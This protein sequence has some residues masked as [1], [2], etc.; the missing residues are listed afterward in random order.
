MIT[1][2]LYMN[3]YIY[4]WYLVYNII[5]IRS[6]AFCPLRVLFLPERGGVTPP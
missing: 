2:T 1:L 4:T 6:S 3:I 5:Y